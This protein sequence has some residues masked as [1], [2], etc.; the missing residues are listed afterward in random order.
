MVGVSYPRL[1]SPMQVAY[2][3]LKSG[4]VDSSHVRNLVVQEVERYIVSRHYGFST[5]HEVDFSE[6]DAVVVA[7]AVRFITRALASLSCMGFSLTST[8]RRRGVGAGSTGVVTA[9]SLSPQAARAMTDM[10]KNSFLIVT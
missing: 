3:V 9:S 2:D 1:S 7:A 10:T 8:V 4:L 5:D 6:P